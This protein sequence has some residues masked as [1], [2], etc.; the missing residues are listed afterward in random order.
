MFFHSLL[1]NS[2]TNKSNQIFG[3]DAFA[4]EVPLLNVSEALAYLFI[5]NVATSMKFCK[6]AASSSF[7]DCVWIVIGR[8]IFCFSDQDFNTFSKDWKQ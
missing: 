2:R 6:I 5:N 1:Q 7:N 3:S 8:S 4:E